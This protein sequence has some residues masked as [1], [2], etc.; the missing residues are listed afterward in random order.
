MKFNDEVNGETSLFFSILPE[1]F[2][3]H[4][5]NGIKC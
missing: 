5:G 2:E 4:I 3:K 1:N